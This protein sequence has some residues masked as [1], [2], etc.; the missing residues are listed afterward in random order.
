MNPTDEPS[1]LTVLRGEYQGGDES[2]V[3]LC[4]STYSWDVDA[5]DRTTGAMYEA[6]VALQDVEQ[7]DRWLVQAFWK[8]YRLVPGLS[9]HPQFHRPPDPY[10]RRA[11]ERIEHLTEWF[12]AGHQ[13]IVGDWP[14]IVA[15][16]MPW[17][18]IEQGLPT[19]D[20]LIS[21]LIAK[22]VTGDIDIFHRVRNLLHRLP[23]EVVVAEVDRQIAASF[24]VADTRQR[25]RQLYVLIDLCTELTLAAQLEHIVGLSATDEDLRE[26]HDRAVDVRRDERWGTPYSGW[27]S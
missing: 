4:R 14:R 9:A 5:F 19:E 10:Y 27:E 22:A 7:F 17:P 2:F 15:P 1:Y 13:P 26:L 16:P 25:A 3:F 8:V 11:I 21:S 12:M 24:H 20:Q 18:R 6:C 23:L